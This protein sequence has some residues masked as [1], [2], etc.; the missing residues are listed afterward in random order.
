M[1]AYKLGLPVF[2]PMRDSHVDFLNIMTTL[3][4][5]VKRVVHRH[6]D[7]SLKN[8][9]ELLGG[10]TV[11][12][13]GAIAHEGFNSEIISEIPLDRLMIETESSLWGL[14]MLLGGL[15]AGLNEPCVISFVVKKIAELR[16]D[17]SEAE[18]AN[19]TSK[20]AKGFLRFT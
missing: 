9:Q 11:G 13:T 18:I 2:L 14:E 3:S 4:G 10:W 6:T 1:L 16:K 8:L 17:C 15:R 12:L 20:V 19:C 5:K 7:P